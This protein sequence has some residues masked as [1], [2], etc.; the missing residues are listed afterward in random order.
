MKR[1]LLSIYSPYV[2]TV[3]DFV[4]DSK[5]QSSTNQHLAAL[6]GIVGNW[7]N[8]TSRIAII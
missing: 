5:F 6:L 8:P 1:D 7:I 2:N 3:T 4:S